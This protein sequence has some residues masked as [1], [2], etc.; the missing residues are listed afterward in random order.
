MLWALEPLD[1]APQ[2]VCMLCKRQDR[3]GQ[4][5]AGQGKAGERAHLKVHLQHV[6]A[7]GIG[8]AQDEAAQ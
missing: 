6:N 8:T 2:G 1:E 5:R 4:G 3:A 7:L